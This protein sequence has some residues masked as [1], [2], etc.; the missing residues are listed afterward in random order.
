[1][2][3]VA[4]AGGVGGAKLADGLSR[5]IPPSDLTVIVNTGDDFTH[6]GL[7]VC[8]DLDTVCYTL[9]GLANPETGWGRTG[10][11]YNALVNA[12]ALGG[13]D[14][15]R[16]GDQDLGTHME[17]TRRLR[18]G[19]RLTDITLDFCRSWGIQTR[20]LPMCDDPVETKVETDAYGWLAFQE[21]FV[22]YRFQPK[23]KRFR[24]DGC[25]STRI[26]VEVHDAL[27]NADCVI[28]CPSNPWVSIGPML[29]IDGMLPLLAGCP[30][31][32]G[33]SPIVGGQAI[34]GPAAKMFREL[35][36]EP[37][38]VAVAKRYQPWL[39]A[40]IIDTQD[41]A[42]AP[43]FTD[44]GIQTRSTDTIMSDAQKRIDLAKFTL[45]FCHDLSSRD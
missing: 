12:A 39:K 9:A 45:Q 1:M 8:P 16:L 6:F 37:S 5:V 27:T 30:V 43:Q 10:E 24:F 28:V 29:S 42:Q 7:R 38:P 22:R 13:P 3:V 20:V 17:R 31:T 23:V 40:F 33:V 35:G 2:N 32:V 26:S 41:A 19:C 36:I 4:L 25:E 15:F 11:T 14:W 34:K 44:L 21:Y 18:D